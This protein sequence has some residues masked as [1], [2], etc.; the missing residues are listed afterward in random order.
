MG[1]D[2]FSSYEKCTK[3]LGDFSRSKAGEYL[4]IGTHPDRQMMIYEELGAIYEAY[5]VSIIS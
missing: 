2:S 5:I 4:E 3:Q 1:L